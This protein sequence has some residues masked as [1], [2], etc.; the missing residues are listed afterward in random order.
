MIMNDNLKSKAELIEE[1]ESLRNSVA[2]KERNRLMHDV[3]ERV[4]ELQCLYGISESIRTRTLLEEIFQD[5][6]DLIPP[7]WNYPEITRGKVIFDGIEY[8]SAPF[9]QTEWRQSSEIIVDGEL[10]GTVEVYYLEAR[11][12]IDEGPFMAEERQLIDALADRLAKVVERKQVE[13]KR[14]TLEAQLRQ[15][16]KLEAIGTMVGGIS[17]EFNNLLQAQYLYLSI[18]R[19]QLPAQ[20]E[21]ETT[22]KHLIDLGERARDLV[23]RILIFSRQSETAFKPLKIQDILLDSI[24]LVNSGLPSNIRIEQNIDPDAAPV[25][26]DQ[27]QVQQIILNLCNNAHHAIDNKSGLLTISLREVFVDEVEPVIIESPD[28]QKLIELRIRDNG[29]GMKPKTLEKIFDPFFTTKE[30]GKGT[31]LGLSVVHGIVQEMSGHISVT[32]HPGKGTTFTLFFPTTTTQAIQPEEIS[33]S[34]PHL[35]TQT[36]LLVDDELAIISSGKPILERYG[37]EVFTATNGSDALKMVREEPSKF[38]LIITDLTMPN[39]SGLEFSE[40][41]F[42]FLPDIPIILATGNMNDDRLVDF[43]TKGIR[44]LLQKP[45][46][47]MELLERLIELDFNQVVR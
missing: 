3:Q 8:L 6:A 11:P 19:K 46:T 40:E 35:W 25:M 32:S 7:A 44:S 45:W 33:T 37:F 9:S 30:V 29:P 5:L 15:A 36:I 43:G 22:M 28:T 18:M 16:Q 10:R 24:Q 47:Q 13:Q 2:E 4:K 21:Y 23:K 26:A 34:H 31:G 42:S 12:T 17:H 20:G 14:L 39:M 38:H 41:V 27:G 1:L